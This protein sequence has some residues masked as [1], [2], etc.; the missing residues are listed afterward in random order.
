MKLKQLGPIGL[1]G[2]VLAGC[3]REEA[4]NAEDQKAGQVLSLPSDCTRVASL[5]ETSHGSGL[6]FSTAYVSCERADG[7]YSLWEES[8]CAEREWIEIKRYRLSPATR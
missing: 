7:S 6:R 1:A 3:T 2:L 8:D 5:G 4:R